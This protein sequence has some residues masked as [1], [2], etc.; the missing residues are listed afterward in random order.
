LSSGDT[1]RQRLLLGAG[2]EQRKPD[3]PSN[4]FDDDLQGGRRYRDD[5]RRQGRERGDA[6]WRDDTDDPLH[7]ETTEGVPIDDDMFAG[8]EYVTRTGRMTG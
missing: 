3:G 7:Q 2:A 6:T 5:G 1:V 8:A 4:L